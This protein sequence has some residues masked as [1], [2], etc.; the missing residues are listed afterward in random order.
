MRK[1]SRKIKLLKDTAMRGREMKRTRNW[2]MGVLRYR[3]RK[4]KER[5][6]VR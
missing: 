2:W 3:V 6:E 1:M 4:G 5:R